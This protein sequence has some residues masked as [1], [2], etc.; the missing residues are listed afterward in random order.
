VHAAEA[1]TADTREAAGAVHAG[2]AGTANAS[3]TAGA[4]R[5]AGAV[6]AAGAVLAGGAGTANAPGTAGAVLAG[7]AGTANAPGTAGAVLAGGAGTANAPGT[8]G[9]PDADGTGEQGQPCRAASAGSSCD[10]GLT[11]TTADICAV[12]AE[13]GGEGQAC[14]ADRT[15][16]EG[17]GCV[18]DRA[19]EGYFRCAVGAGEQ[20]Q[21]CRAA[22]AGSSCDE[23]LTCT[24]AGVCVVADEFGDE[25]QPCSA[26]YACDE[27]LG[28]VFD[29]A[30]EGYYRCVAGAGEQGRP[31]RSPLPVCDEEL[32]C[33]TASLCSAPADFG[34]EDQPCSTDHECDEGLGCVWDAFVD[35]YHQCVVGAGEHGQ[36]CRSRSPECDEGLACTTADVCSTPAEFGGESQP[37]GSDGECEEGL[38]CLRSTM[39]AG[40]CCVA[41]AGQAGQQCRDLPANAPCDEGLSC[42]ITD[43]CAPPSESGGDGQVCRQNGECDPG[44]GCVVSSECGGVG[45]C[46]M[47]GVG[48]ADQPCR[49]YASPECDEGLSCHQWMCRAECIASQPECPA[50]YLCVGSEESSVCVPDEC[51]GADSMACSSE[52]HIVHALACPGSWVGVPSDLFCYSEGEIGDSGYELVCCEAAVSG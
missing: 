44:L 9:V 26:D 18:Y 7:G 42:T 16:D 25:G 22:S 47:A 48:Q 12:G 10:E 41:G 24:T 5:A 52:F 15:C 28:C 49:G 38:G 35:G 3:G 46:C 19:V 29:S 6:H 40:G 14:G 45:P 37:C 34:G 39:C 51:V 17:L 30:V 43:E 1:G 32:T 20:G 11:C 31:C 33:T 21:P 4:V 27:G 23:G 50:D 2:G 13:F 8:P 36:P